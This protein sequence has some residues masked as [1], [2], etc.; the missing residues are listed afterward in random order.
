MKCGIGDF[1]KNVLRFV[2]V[3]DMYM[4]VLTGVS[5]TNGKHFSASIVKMVTRTYHNV[6]LHVY[7]LS[8][9]S[10]S[11]IETLPSDLHLGLPMTLFSS[12]FYT[13]TLQVFLFVLYVSHAPPVNTW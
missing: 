6:T 4:S 1:Y 11:S 7:C 2:V 10:L 9:F 3:C 8:C 13:E 12:G 5:N